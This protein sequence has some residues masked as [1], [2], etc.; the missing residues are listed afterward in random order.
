MSSGRAAQ[1]SPGPTR[2][3]TARPSTTIS[4]PPPAA[5]QKNGC[6][7]C[8]KSGR[9]R[10]AGLRDGA[11]DGDAQRRADLPAR[12]GDRRRQPGPRARHARDRGVGDGRVDQS[13]AHAE[14]H[15]G[16]RRATAA[17]CARRAATASARSTAMRAP[18]STQRQPR[19]ALAD[20]PAR[21]RRADDR[22]ERER[23][24][25]EAGLERRQAAHLLQVERVEEEEAREGRRTRSRR[26]RSRSRTARCGRSAGRAA[27]R[28]GAARRRAVPSAAPA[29][30]SEQRHDERRAPA[31]V[32]ALDDGVGD[33]G[34]RAQHQQPAR[35]DR[36]AAPAAPWTRARSAGRARSR[37]RR[38]AG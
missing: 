33:G 18:A 16:A 14:D 25:V 29:A 38:R 32:R 3:S 34:E 27:A 6:I 1:A 21:D 11:A 35:P 26:S 23:Q 12:R 10:A 30:P 24:R 2:C 19:A 9:A 28:R 13:E 15:V 17:A 8:A 7:A 31:V 22:R 5:S 4:A 37:P 36:R 20:E